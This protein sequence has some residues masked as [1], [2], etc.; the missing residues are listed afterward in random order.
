M[1]E[2]VSSTN[3][4]NRG[5]L[6]SLECEHRGCT[7]MGTKWSL[8]KHRHAKKAHPVEVCRG[9]EEDCEGCKKVVK[10]NIRS[11][12]E[13]LMKEESLDY[14]YGVEKFVCSDQG[15]W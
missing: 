15:F 2:H 12:L 10:T 9:G 7:Y 11:R 13:R 4:N 1:A 8:R 14:L 5:S 3:S 6:E